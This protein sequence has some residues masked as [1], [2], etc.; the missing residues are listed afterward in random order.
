MSKAL[1]LVA[2][3][4]VAKGVKGMDWTSSNFSSGSPAFADAGG[5]KIRGVNLGGWLILENWMTSALFGVSPLDEQAVPDEWTYCNVLGKEECATRLEEHWSTYIVEEDFKLIQAAGLN[6]VRI[7]IGYWAFD[8]L[9][10]PYV[11]GQINHLGNALKW[12]KTY[13]LDVMV[14]LHG[15]PGSQNGLDNSGKYGTIAWASNS[16]N[17]DRS[18]N[19]LELLTAEVTKEDYEGV[20]KAIEVINEPYLDTMFAGGAT[21]DQLADYYVRAYASIRDKEVILDSAAPVT[22][23]IH[24]AFQA[25]LNWEYFFGN[26]SLGGSCINFALDTHIYEAFNGQ[27]AMTHEEHMA[28]MCARTAD[29]AEVSKN[30]TLLVGEWSLGTQTYCVDYQTCYNTTMEQ[31]LNTTQEESIFTEQ[32]YEV[33]RGIYETA[34]G[35]IFWNW[36]SDAAP[37]WS[38]FQSQKQGWIG[39]DLTT[40]D[41]IFNASASSNCL[42]L[43]SNLATPTFPSSYVGSTASSIS[44]SSAG[45]SASSSSGGSL[46]NPSR[47]GWSLASVGILVLGLVAL[48]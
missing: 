10:E 24:D 46:S 36:K 26:T 34:A 48:P 1:A 45:V 2:L 44:N 43:R 7:P 14:D 6:T 18:I 42:V 12:A 38:F 40:S 13:D 47:S 11:Q 30:I 9:D 31:N 27:D 33:Q 32:Y 8:L 3:L 21:F 15:L 19:A 20:V 39:E 41:Y 5:D 29:I 28:S 17:V 37:T 4:A 16:S 35:W 25:V 22:V 23:V